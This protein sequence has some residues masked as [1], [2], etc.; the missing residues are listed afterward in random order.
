MTAAV[1]LTLAAVALSAGVTLLVLDRR[2]RPDLE[3]PPVEPDPPVADLFTPTI[4]P[5]STR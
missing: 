1:W 2:R 4:E 5:R 3:D